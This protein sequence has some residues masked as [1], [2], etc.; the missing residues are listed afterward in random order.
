MQT[1]CEGMRGR[2]VFAVAGVV[3]RGVN[4]SKACCVTGG[5]GRGVT[6]QL[7]IFCCS[8][9]Q[10][11]AVSTLLP[12]PPSPPLVFSLLMT[13]M[14][15]EYQPSAVACV[16]IHLACHWKEIE[17]RALEEDKVQ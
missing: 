11:S 9:R 2:E 4:T 8:F 7:P 15:L 5:G 14:C 12:P 6:T 13:T 1:C 17:V 10:L 3:C 16:C